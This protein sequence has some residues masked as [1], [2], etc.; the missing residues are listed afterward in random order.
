MWQHIAAPCLIAVETEFL[1]Q[2]I[3]ISLTAAGMVL[4]KEIKSSD[5]PASMTICGKG[6]TLTESMIGR[7]QQMGIQSVTVEGH[8]ILVK[9]EATLEQMLVSLDQRFSRVADDPL[10][11]KVKEIYR[12]QILRSMGDTGGR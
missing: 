3:P 1:M 4:A 7:L 6:V 5:G 11:S 8:P 2:N 9:G 10:M 12:K